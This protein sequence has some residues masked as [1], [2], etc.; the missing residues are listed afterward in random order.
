MTP[1]ELERHLLDAPHTQLY[2]PENEMLPI[3]AA[4]LRS[5]RLESLEEAAKIAETFAAS[6]RSVSE[7]A[8]DTDEAHFYETMRGEVDR[9]AAAIRERAKHHPA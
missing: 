8:R 9:L 6:W 1:E 7:K 4:A 3:L 2:D 5:A